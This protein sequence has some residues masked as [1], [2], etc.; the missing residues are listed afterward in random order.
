[1]CSCLKQLVPV[2]R[3]VWSL[4]LA[5]VCIFYQIKLPEDDINQI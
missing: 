2:C 1:M 3:P 4:V 5:V